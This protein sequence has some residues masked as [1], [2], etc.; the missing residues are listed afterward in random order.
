MDLGIANNRS[1][2][3]PAIIRASLDRKQGGMVGL[4]KNMWP[5]VNI[6]ERAYPTRSELVDE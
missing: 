3:I 1:R 6:E 5:N 2:Q 4:G